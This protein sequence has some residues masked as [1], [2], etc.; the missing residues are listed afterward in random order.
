MIPSED[1]ITLAEEDTLQKACDLL[2]TNRF[3]FL[4]VV[5]GSGRCLGKLTALKLVS[6]LRRLVAT[7]RD[8]EPIGEKERNLLAGSISSLIDREHT[9]FPPDAVVKD[10]QRAIG[11]SNEG[12]FIILGENARAGRRDH[13]REL[14][15]REQAAR[16]HGGPQ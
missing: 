5:D 11:K 10:V 9:T 12:G 13:P 1:L 6:V 15:Q 2:T 4:P 16:R 3:S 8:D 14:H 7:C